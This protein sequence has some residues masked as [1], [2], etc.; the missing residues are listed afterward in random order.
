MASGFVPNG[1]G[2]VPDAIKDP[3]IAWNVRAR[4]NPWFQKEEKISLPFR[5][6]SKLRT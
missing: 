5:D 3:P 4:K 1:P 6:K 2:S